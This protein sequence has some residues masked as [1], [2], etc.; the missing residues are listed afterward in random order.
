MTARQRASV[1]SLGTSD[2]GSLDTRR[3]QQE[4][5]RLEAQSRAMLRLCARL[6]EE[7]RSLREQQRRLVDERAHLIEKNE[8]A[9]TKVEQMI[10]RLKAME[11][12][13]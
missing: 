11:S 1:D 2:P 3:I 6:A 9:R 12:A 7:N 4:L 5:A 13:T 10:V 8:T